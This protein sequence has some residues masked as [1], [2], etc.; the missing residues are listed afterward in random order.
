MK[1]DM[2]RAWSQAM[3][4]LKANRDLVL[5][6]AG[7]FFFLPNLALVLMVPDLASQLPMTQAETDPRVMLDALLALYAKLWLPILAMVVLQ[8]VGS[9]SLIA[10]LRDPGRPTLGE[11]IKLGLVGFLTYLGAQLLLGLAIGVPGGVLV[12]G[13]AALSPALAVIVIL[14]LIVVVAYVAIKLSLTMPVIG[15]ERVYNPIAALS[16]SWALTKGNSFRLFLFYL[17]IVIAGVV[18]VSVVQMI[19]GLVFAMFGPQGQLFG[20]GIVSS[21]LNSGWTAVL[22]A[23]IAAAHQQLSG[24]GAANEG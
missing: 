20:D 5:V 1:L 11:A 6:M 3:A 13:S 19:F 12:A 21:L 8:G 2:G 18:V 15:A 24:G 16:R 14:L 10:L 17:L 9:L 23:V 4:M 22:L 7:V